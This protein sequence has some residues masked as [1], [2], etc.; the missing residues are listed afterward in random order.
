MRVKAR[1]AQWPTH[2]GRRPGA[3]TT[4][5]ARLVF[6]TWKHARCESLKCESGDLGAP[7]RL[8]VLEF[9][10]RTLGLL[11]RILL[12]PFLTRVL[13]PSSVKLTP[14]TWLWKWVS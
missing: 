5:C 3:H 11:A 1:E 8:A 6:L 4:A 14:N 7:T 2:Y 9:G 13:R 10:Y 12:T